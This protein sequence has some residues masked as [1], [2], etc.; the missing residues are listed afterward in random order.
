MNGDTPHQLSDFKVNVPGHIQELNQAFDNGLDANTSDREGY[1]ARDALPRQKE[2]HV[3]LE[4]SEIKTVFEL[5][6]ILE[7]DE[8]DGGSLGDIPS[9]I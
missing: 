3:V 7:E 4:M 2:P 5:V 9:Q 1:M 8:G 6:P